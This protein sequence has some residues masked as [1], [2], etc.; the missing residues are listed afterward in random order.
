MHYL[1]YHEQ[2]P[3]RTGDFP[4]DYYYVDENFPRYRMTM[5]WHK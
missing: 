2:I 4:L 3:H 1:D 5:H